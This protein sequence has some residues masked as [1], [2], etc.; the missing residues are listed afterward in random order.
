M[1]LS[2]DRRPLPDSRRQL[3]RGMAIAA[4]V[5][6][7][8]TAGIVLGYSVLSRGPSSDGSVNPPAAADPTT[9][10]VTSIGS[11]ATASPS[12][13]SGGPSQP[14]ITQ[15]TITQP[16]PPTGSGPSG[17]PGAPSG[18]SIAANDVLPE[19]DLTVSWH[20]AAA[21]GHAIT[22][23]RVA[24]R[25]SGLAPLDPVEASGLSTTF[26][27]TCPLSGCENPFLDGTVSVAAINSRG[28]GPTVSYPFSRDLPKITSLTCGQSGPTVTCTVATPN[29]GTYGWAVNFTVVTPNDSRFPN[30][31]Q[32]GCTPGQQ[33]AIGVSLS[34]SDGTTTR[35]TN[36]DCAPAS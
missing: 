1:S 5:M 6:I 21:N 14:T 10:A 8:L 24:A 3:F 34:D 15:P 13:A 33:N 30:Q 2:G 35:F 25:I 27:F 7:A 12:P 9:S 26:K 17:L 11:T 20:A 16:R 36:F 23:Y 22:S 29:T 32:F 19:L 18:I 28:T 31:I 4:S